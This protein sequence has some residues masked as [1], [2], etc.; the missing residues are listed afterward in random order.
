M[1]NGSNAFNQFSAFNLNAPE[2]VPKFGPPTSPN[3]AAAIPP[4]QQ[5]APP[6]P[7]PVVQTLPETIPAPV[8]TPKVVPVAP[9]VHDSVADL[10]ESSKAPQM[11]NVKEDEW[12]EGGAAASELNEDMSNLE[13]EAE[14]KL[15]EEDAARPK[16]KALVIREYKT[17]KR[18]NQ[19]YLLWSRRCR[20]IY[21]RRSNYVF[22]WYG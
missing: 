6:Q 9:V 7:A 4:V 15:G 3:P 10:V 1:S 2:F 18:T 5:Q 14:D 22:D 19:R 13:L 11:S 16:K 21:N 20:Q 17:K 12:D 8:E